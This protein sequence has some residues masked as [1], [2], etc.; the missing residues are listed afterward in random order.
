LTRRSF[1]LVLTSCYLNIYINNNVVVFYLNT[2]SQTSKTSLYKSF[3][4]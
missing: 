3:T 1:G 2:E 4:W